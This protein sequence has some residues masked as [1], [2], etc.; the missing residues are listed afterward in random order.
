MWIYRCMV[1]FEHNTSKA[2]Y[3]WSNRS[4]N[5]INNYKKMSLPMYS[6]NQTVQLG[7][8]ILFI[9]EFE[10]YAPVSMFM[11]VYQWYEKFVSWMQFWWLFTSKPCEL[12]ISRGV[13]RLGR[14]RGIWKNSSSLP[15]LTY[16]LLLQWLMMLKRKISLGYCSVKRH[17]W[18]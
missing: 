10:I 8:R 6:W 3:A 18:H 7:I 12:E 9:F 2:L 11:N 13:C 4:Y 1:M 5:L 17:K 14:K 16:D 15:A